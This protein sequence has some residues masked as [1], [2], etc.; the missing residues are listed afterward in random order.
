MWQCS[1]LESGLSDELS[2]QT[3]AVGTVVA[4]GVVA[5][6]GRCSGRRVGDN[7]LQA[8]NSTVTVRHPQP[9]AV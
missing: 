2:L 4:V 1:L 8:F 6:P 3:D 5:L 9:A 7:E